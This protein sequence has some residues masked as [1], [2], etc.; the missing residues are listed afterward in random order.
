[1]RNRQ[2]GAYSFLFLVVLIAGGLLVF[3][4]AADGARLYA[5]QRIL[6]QQADAAALAAAQG[7]QACGGE[8][9]SQNAPCLLAQEAAAAA[10]FDGT[11]SCG[12]VESGLLETGP[13][14]ISRFRATPFAG[15]NG[16]SVTL[17][18]T[19]PRSLILPGRLGGSVEL[20]ASSVAV[21]ELVATFSTGGSTAVV[22]SS[23]GE[24]SLLGDLLGTILLGPGN[25]FALNPTNLE[26]LAA[27][28]VTVGDLLN[29]LGVNSIAALLPLSGQ[30]LALALEAVAGLTG[31]VAEVL[32]AVIASPGI[33]TLQLSDVLNIVGDTEVPAGSEFPVYD[34]LM[35]L[36]LNVSEGVLFNFPQTRIAI[37]GV[38]TELGLFIAGAPSVVIGPA[39]QGD[40]GEW[41]TR[42]EAPDVRLALSNTVNLGPTISIPLVGSLQLGSIDLPLIIDTGTGTASFVAAECAS[43]FSND[44]RMTLE[45][46]S[47]V[48]L[49]GTGSVGAGGVT[50]I[51]PINVQIGRL[52]LLPLVFGGITIDPA[53]GVS[54]GLNVSIP[55][56]ED[57]LTFDAVLVADPADK[58]SGRGYGATELIP[59]GAIG[60]DLTLQ[61]PPALTLLGGPSISLGPITNT[62]T[63]ILNPAISQVVSLVATPLL[64]SLGVELGGFS[65]TLI[66]VR[67]DAT[68]LVRNVERAD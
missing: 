68:R 4:L 65:A 37:P 3:A 16:V 7:T 57:D 59:G 45:A 41:V 25:S 40:D 49:V 20:T 44:V 61:P 32:D 60:L 63:G 24:A 58:T 12:D 9:V 1:M 26:S 46:R 43:G 15:G 28:T 23:T 13:D 66:D 47:S 48:A 33:D 5:Q 29:E 18:R 42:L 22:G 19:S 64:G 8:G 52:Q 53:L 38:S 17:R 6:Q 54:T 21:K 10:G 35:S 36:V 31:P 39:R 14:Q 56:A 11:L 27:A 62:I 30:D 2:R 67:Q 51:S 50:D 34:L 55:A